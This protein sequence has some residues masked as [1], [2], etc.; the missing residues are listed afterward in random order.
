M[1]FDNRAWGWK[2]AAALAVVALLGVYSAVR[3][4]GLKPSLARCLA[5][6][7][8]WDGAAVWITS[9]TVAQTSPE[10]WVLRTDGHSVRIPGPAPAGAGADVS[11]AGRFRADGPRIDPTRTRLLPASS[12]TRRWMELLSITVALLVLFNAARA[13]NFDPKRLQVERK[14]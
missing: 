14:D 7:A 9:G 1:I 10:A 8:R 13:F 3:G 4:S 6:P 5:E 12:L 11:L 2:L